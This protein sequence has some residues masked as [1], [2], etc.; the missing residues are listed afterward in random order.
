M[1][2]QK[3]PYKTNTYHVLF[4]RE[5]RIDEPP[6]EVDDIVIRH[7][8]NPALNILF[9]KQAYKKATEKFSNTNDY[10]FEDKLWEDTCKEFNEW[11]EE[12]KDF[13]T[14]LKNPND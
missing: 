13:V 6:L 11:C 3:E 9:G 12:L 1:E 10:N 5:D 2:I 7:G 4:K 8:A 14:T